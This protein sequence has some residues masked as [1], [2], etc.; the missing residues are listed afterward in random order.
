VDIPGRLSLAGCDDV[1][2]ARQLYPTLTTIR[3]PL[4]QMARRAALVLID[5]AGND[6]PL[7]G[8]EI[9]P[10]TIVL[11]ESTAPPQR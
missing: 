3:Q 11:R 10:A 9:V 6:A 5:N 8:F 7:R 4:L 2:L 1:S